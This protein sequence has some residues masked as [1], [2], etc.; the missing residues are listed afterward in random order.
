M[1]DDLKDAGVFEPV[2]REGPSDCSK[3]KKDIAGIH[4]MKVLAAMI[5]DLHYESLSELLKELCEK[6]YEDGAKDRKSDRVKLGFTLQNASLHISRAQ[7][8]IHEAY[9][10]SKPF[11]SS[12]ARTEES[13]Q[14][15]P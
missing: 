4:D 9:L 2:D 14:I 7:M 5:G 11:M 12:T 1:E 6:L 10:I 3:H 15:E 8:A 13:G